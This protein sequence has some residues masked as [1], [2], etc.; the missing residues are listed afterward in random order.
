MI[1]KHFMKYI[2]ISEIIRSYIIIKLNIVHF[3]SKING[4]YSIHCDM[5]LYRQ[6]YYNKY[7][8]IVHSMYKTILFK[9]T[10]L[11]FKYIYV[12]YIYVNQGQ[13]GD[14]NSF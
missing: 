3:C 10:E 11:Y 2:L 1:I 5:F 9:Y 6:I 12:L 4:K 13:N 7:I 14:K 8:I